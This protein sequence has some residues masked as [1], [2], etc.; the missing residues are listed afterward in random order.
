MYLNG[1]NIG[2]VLHSDLMIN[3]MYNKKSESLGQYLIVYASILT[4]KNTTLHVFD[5]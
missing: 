2:K 1:I 4:D 5:G 3:F